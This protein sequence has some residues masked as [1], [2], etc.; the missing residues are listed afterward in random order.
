M[1]YLALALLPG[2]AYAAAC[3]GTGDGTVTSVCTTAAGLDC[4]SATCTDT[5]NCLVA[6]FSAL[7]SDMCM[8]APVTSCASVTGATTACA[9]ASSELMCGSRF[10]EDGKYCLDHATSGVGDMCLG[11]AKG[12]CNAVDGTAACTASDGKVVCGSAH[13]MDG[14]FCLNNAASTIGDICL[15]A[16]LTACPALDGTA[17]CDQTQGTLQCGA[18]ICPHLY[19]CVSSANNGGNGDLCV[20]PPPPGYG[21]GVTN[22]DLGGNAMYPNTGN[23]YLDHINNGTSQNTNRALHPDYYLGHIGCPGRSVCKEQWIGNGYCDDCFGCDQYMIASGFYGDCSTCDYFWTG[24]VVGEGE[25][26]GGDCGDF[27]F[28]SSVNEA[29]LNDCLNKTGIR[30]DADLNTL[31]Y[32]QKRNTIIVELNAGGWGEIADLQSDTDVTLAS[33]CEYMNIKQCLIKN[34]WYQSSMTAWTDGDLKFEA[35][36]YIDDLST[37]TSIQLVE[38]TILAHLEQCVLAGITMEMVQNGW[39]TNAESTTMT[40][41]QKRNRAINALHQL[42]FGTT[43]QLQTLH[44]AQV[45]FLMDHLSGSGLSPDNNDWPGN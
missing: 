28:P 13:C 7:A 32:N 44:N 45:R 35:S 39:A 41:D 11:N 26:D 15:G 29:F 34:A 14:H 37:F 36:T 8:N 18:A 16:A 33:K 43:A 20:A 30:L 40:S 24:G 9:A 19:S 38:M 3:P 6:A 5:Q 31:S 21:E 27:V 23:Y 25:F 22:L 2:F 42:G 4:G 10:C 17:A 12:A 1:N